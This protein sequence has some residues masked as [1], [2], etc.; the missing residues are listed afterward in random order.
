[1]YKEKD[2]MDEMTS[3]LVGSAQDLIEELVSLLLNE[4]SIPVKIA[5][6]SVKTAISFRDAFFWE[7]FKR[8]LKGG[9][10]NEEDRAKFYG[11]L[12]D[13]NKEKKRENARRIIQIIDSAETEKKMDFI[14]NA[15]FSFVYSYIDKTTYFRICNVINDT[16]QEDLEF[17]QRNYTEEG[18]LRYG[19]EVQGLIRQGL[20]EKMGPQWHEIGEEIDFPDS[21]KFTALAKYVD[22]YALSNSDFER[23]PE[24]LHGGN[25]IGNPDF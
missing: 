23:Y 22:K 2:H 6:T 25:T 4:A 13:E 14:V 21:Y 17:L 15:T 7:K 9:D 20:M 1:M 19:D 16:L 8:L 12:E 11:K 24:L 10:L 3:A 5:A 18:G